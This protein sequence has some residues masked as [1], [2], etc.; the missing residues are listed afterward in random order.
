MLIKR[1]DKSFIVELEDRSTWRIWPGDLATTLKWMPST[2]LSLVE[3]DDEFCTHAL[4]DQAEGTRAR[5]IPANDQWSPKVV[6]ERIEDTLTPDEPSSPSACAPEFR[7]ENLTA[8]TTRHFPA[9]WS[10]RELEQAFRVEDANGHAVAYTYFRRDENEARQAN[11]L[12]HDEAR[13][14]AANIAKLPEL[15]RQEK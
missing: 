5:V 6:A 14:I 2:Q 12:T 8:P 7:Q 13:R 10:V 1:H 9:P 15:L 11:V 3:I 4:V